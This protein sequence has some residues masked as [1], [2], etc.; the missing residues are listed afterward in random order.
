MD[1]PEIIIETKEGKE[2]DDKIIDEQN[3]LKEIKKYSSKKIF[4]ITKELENIIPIILS[5]IQNEKNLIINKLEVINYLYLLIKNVPYN[6]EIIMAIKSSEENH[7]LNLYEILVEQYIYIDKKEKKYIN[8]LAELL[9]LIFNKYSYNK[10]IYGHIFSYISNFLNKKNNNQSSEAINLNDYNYSQILNLIHMFYQSKKEDRPFNFFFFNGN[11]NTNISINNS[12]NLLDTNKN[13]FI[14]FFTQLIDYEFLSDLFQYNEKL[15]TNLNLVQINFKNNSNIFNINIDYKNTLLTTDYKENINNINIPYNLF[16]Q[17]DINNV[18]IKI[19]T[20]NQVEIYINGNDINITKNPSAPKNIPLENIIFSGEYYGIISSIMIYKGSEKNKME[21]LIPNYFLDKESSK[22]NKFVFLSSYKY[23]FDEEN[24]LSPFIRADIKDQINLK[25]IKDKS[26]YGSEIKNNNIDDISKFLKYNLISIYI[27]TRIIEHKE[28]GNKKFLLNDS[29]NNLNAIFNINE[30]YPNLLYSKY[31]GI[32]LLQNQIRDFSVDL[33]G[34]NHLL[35]CIEIMVNYPELLT[36]ENLS[37]FMTIILNIILY[38]QNMISREENNNLFY[39]LSQF[40]EK[41]PEERRSDLHAFTKSILIT[42]QSFEG[43]NEQNKL[44]NL[45]IQDFFNNVCMNETI[46]F[47]FNYDERSVIY[48]NIYNFLINESK[49]KIELNIANIISILLR[50]EENKYTHFC[51]KTHANYFKTNSNIMEPELNKSLQPI[52][53]IISLIFKQYYND[54]KS[55]TSQ[56]IEEAKQKA[57]YNSQE[58]LIK[59]FEILTFDITPCLQTA[60]L[61]LYFEFFIKNKGPYFDCLN[62]NDSLILITIFVFKTS[63]F[64][65]K[66][67]AFNYLIEVIPNSKSKVFLG[68]LAKYVTYYN[69]PRINTNKHLKSIPKSIK[70]DKVNYK[71]S[72][73]DENKKKLMDI[74]DK[75]HYNVIMTNIFNKTKDIFLSKKIQGF[76]NI[77]IEIASKCNSIFII[78]FLNLVKEEAFKTDTNSYNYCQAIKNNPKLIQFLLDTCYQAYLMRFSKEQNLEFNLGFDLEDKNNE[79]KKFKIIEDIISLSSTILQDL[80]INDIYKLDFLMTWGKYYY[81]LEETE[82]KYKCV[83]KFI[84]EFFLKNIINR[85][86]PKPNS[87]NKYISNLSKIVY[88]INIVFEYITYHKTSGFEMIGKLKDRELLLQQ[89]YP[90]FAIN[91]FSEIQKVEKTKEMTKENIE[92]DKIYSLEKK[93]EEYNIISSLIDNSDCLGIETNLKLKE[94]NKIFYNYI[95]EKENKF[96]NDLKKYFIKINNAEHFSKNNLSFFDCNKGMELAIIKYHYFTQVLNIITDS[97]EFKF[98]LNNF[99]YFIL[100]IIISSTTITIVNQKNVNTKTLMDLWPNETEY[101]NLQDLVKYLLTYS[102]S[103]LNDKIAEINNKIES[104]RIKKDEQSAENYNLIKHYLINTILLFLKILG[105]IYKNVKQKE[106]S[107]KNTSGFKGMLNKFKDYISPDKQGMHLSG[108]YNFI[109][110]FISSCLIKNNSYDNSETEQVISTF[111]DDIPD[112][113]LISIDK[114]GFLEDP[115]CKKLEEIYNNNIVNNEKISDFLFKSKD[116]YQLEIFPFVDFIIKRS[117]LISSL[118]PTYDNSCNFKLDYNNMC[119]KP[120]YLPEATNSFITLENIDYFSKQLIQFIRTY[121][122]EQ[123]YNSNNKI[124]QYRKIKKK[125]FAFNGIFST[126]KYFYDKKNYICKYKLL[127]HMTEDFTKIFLTPIIDIDYYLPK[128]SKY[129]VKNLFRSKNQDNLIQI[130]KITNLCLQDKE[131]AKTEEK[132]D[133]E[134]TEEKI[135]EIIEGETTEEKIEEIKEGGISKEIIEEKKETD[136]TGETIDDKKNEYITSKI[137]EEDIKKNFNELYL[138]RQSEYKYM[139]ELNKDIEGSLSHYDSYKNYIKRKHKIINNYHFCIENCCYVKTALHIRGFFYVNDEEIGFYS[140]DKIPYKI[141]VKKS[142]RKNKDE[143]VIYSHNY[144]KEEIKQINEIQNDY[145]AE[146]KSCFGSVFWPQKYKYD[147]FHFSIPYDQIVLVLKRRYYYKISC[148]EVFATNK[149]T[150]FFK[151]DHNKLESILSNIKHHINPKPE[152][153]LIENKTYYNEIGFINPLSEKNN[154]NK[155]IYK[156]SYM[157]LKNIYENWRKWKISTLNLLMLFNIYSNRTFNDMNQYPVFPWIFTD[158]KSETFPENIKNKIRP[159]DCPMG[160]LE[161]SEESKERKREYISHWEIGREEDDDGENNFDRYGSHYSTSLYAS[162]YLF[163]IFPHSNIR[164]E[165]Q[166][167]SFDDPNRLFNSLDTSFDCSSTQKSDLRELVPELFCCP[168]ILLNN[169]DF[170]LGEIKNNDSGGNEMKLVQGVE[171]PKWCK[172]NPYLFIKKHRELLESNEVSMT[173]NKWFNLVFGSKQN[174]KEANKIHNLFGIQSY[175]EEYEKIYDNLPT[176][177]KDI[178][179]RMLEFGITP[180][181]IFKSDTAQRKMDLEKNIKNQLFFNTLLERNK[182]IIDEKNI[183]TR[184]KVEE[185]QGENKGFIK[186][187]FT[188]N[189]IYYFPKDNNYENIKKNTF[190]IYV[191]DNDYLY[192]YL[193][194]TEKLIVNKEGKEENVK[195]NDDG[196]GNEILDEIKIKTI[197]LKQN[198]KVKLISF[199]HGIMNN[200]QPK[201]WMNNGSILIKGGYWNG[202]I[203]L[204]NFPRDKENRN[205]KKESN[206]NNIYIYSTMEFCP[207]KKIV[208]DQNETFAICGNING[209]I[210][211]YKIDPI[212]KLDW[213][214]DKTINDHN[215]PIISIAIH[216]VLNIVII[217]SENGLC[218]LYTLPYFKLYNSFILGR[219][220]MDNIND[221][222]LCPDIVLISDTP[223]PCFVFYV[224]DKKTIYFYSINGKLLTKYLLNYELNEKSIKLYRDYQFVDYLVLYNFEKKYFE[225]RSMIEFELIGCSPLLNGF[226]FIDFI[227]NWDLEH[228]LVLG[229]I[230]GKNKLFIIYDADNNKINW[231]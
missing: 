145:D 13:L 59:L 110:D 135:E 35:P 36:S 196:I 14:L 102:I 45:Y 149:K 163:R 121:Q 48:I 182:L 202:N 104:Y 8:N 176:E 109:K 217:C 197:E 54:I 44:F 127:D 74:Y 221:E 173:I 146:R 160:M 75:K 131:K 76:F 84:F 23:G 195:I 103:F 40:L 105:N 156:K 137:K 18:L 220:D 97:G 53:K 171:M 185:V 151:L 15:N 61:K 230:E 122:I 205:M 46:L 218:M 215:S 87:N 204:Q 184:L 108:A 209:T 183:K 125:L 67:I 50:E 112:Y 179:C 62:L 124:R 85:I 99:R 141:F 128:F 219:D 153:I 157:N 178:A 100:V 42:L 16:N 33:N 208:L 64:D 201:L 168:E 6:A 180:N 148:L 7:K 130:S 114:S 29:F 98:I 172:N 65:V 136:K 150:Y 88:L 12:K 32:S 69:Y 177:E 41:I 134:T 126:R 78:K 133:G 10:D 101:K 212:N 228:I 132:K 210:Y 198:D 164:I 51:C 60:I 37:K 192:K 25:N 79:T 113:A 80:F 140:Y 17:K 223:L 181:Q 175:V 57:S 9:N 49:I 5:Y 28:N 187:E 214:L 117:E 159:M 144:T 170:N 58:K 166:G 77:L 167:S 68:Q 225:I 165:L 194:K 27:P 83:R 55:S 2:T 154:L 11:K 115:L 155:K 66:E 3:I 207:V 162:Y 72:E 43:N 63:L 188:P 213:A 19:T 216:E 143:A 138:L 90:S 222:I 199:K 73:L 47:Q 24:I 226:E 93:W 106:N 206:I 123:N 158:Y 161:I 94:E 70:I 169:N 107:K 189:K 22:K 21:H 86:I 111:L 152:N 39:L 1:N 95:L 31:G 142:Q 211:I 190:E 229:K 91:L 186:T 193:R 26:L 147:Y 116:N 92:E 89:I 224:N 227:F 71:Y 200:L 96:N 120:Y 30:L 38:Y 4:I 191:M 52:L 203:I 231:K 139:D 129:D 56:K 34:I 119:L 118:I 82:N 81:T 174:G 20:E